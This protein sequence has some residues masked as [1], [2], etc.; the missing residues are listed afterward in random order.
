[1]SHIRHSAFEAFD[2][3]LSPTQSEIFRASF[4]EQAIEQL[5][6]ND[7]I[8]IISKAYQAACTAV[9]HV[10]VGRCPRHPSQVIGNG[11]FDSLC[12]ICETINNGDE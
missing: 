3:K 2:R 12:P 7:V 6:E 5:S 9:E 10:P 4:I 8:D 1:M 11:Q